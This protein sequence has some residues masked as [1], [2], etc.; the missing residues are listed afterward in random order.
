MAGSVNETVI[1]ND[2]TWQKP[3]AVSE[4]V[5]AQ[6]IG[7]L[8]LLLFLNGDLHTEALRGTLCRV[9]RKYQNA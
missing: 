9:I 8:L 2:L 7:V 6:S 3:S 5:L 1:L 4:V